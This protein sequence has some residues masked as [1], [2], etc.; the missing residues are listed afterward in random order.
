M[1]NVLQF[2]QKIYTQASIQ[3][4]IEQ[5]RDFGSFQVSSRGKYFEVAI[6]ESSLEG[7][8]DMLAHEFKNYV[9][10]LDITHADH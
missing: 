4:A 9:L 5:F 10:Y 2:H 7:D 8:S 6:P 3:S 1:T